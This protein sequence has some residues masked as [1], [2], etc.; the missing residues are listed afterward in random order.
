MTQGYVRTADAAKY[1]GIGQ[2]TLERKRIDGTGPKFRQL[3][4][5]IIVYALADLDEWAS[6][7]VMSSTSERLAG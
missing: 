6:Q 3:G 4:A 7:S 5:K 1:L 2:S